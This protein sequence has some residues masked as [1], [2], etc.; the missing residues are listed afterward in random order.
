MFLKKKVYVLE[1]Y[2]WEPDH[3]YS[4][5][6]ENMVFT[7]YKKANKELMN[8]K[9]NLQEEADT[10]EWDIDIQWLQEFN[11]LEVKYPNG[12]ID[13]YTILERTVLQEGYN[14]FDLNKD[15]IL[16]IA[17]MSYN[18]QQLPLFFDFLI[19]LLYNIYVINKESDRNE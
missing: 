7:S 4:L 10:M 8:I 13:N 14:M 5:Q 12:T 19:K 11:T 15:I 17:M 1:G 16:Q 9:E 18:E 6:L 2:T 3:Q